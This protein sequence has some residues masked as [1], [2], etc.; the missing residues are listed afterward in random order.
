MIDHL[1]Q[2][3]D[4]LTPEQVSRCLE[5]LETAPW[6]PTTVFGMSGTEVN[7]DIRKNER[8]CVPEETELAE[9]MHSAM[10][11]ALLKYRHEVEYN[12][13]TEF[14]KYPVPGSYRTNSHRESIQVLSYT[15]DEFYNWHYDQATN[16]KDNA[17]HRTISIVLYLQNAEEGGKTI[18]PHRAYKPKAGQ[19]LIFPS[20]WCFPHRG[21]EVLK[22]RKI[23]AVTWYH[24]FYNY[25][26]N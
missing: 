22:G 10:N 8:Y 12:L 18:F 13:H 16:H 6:E 20:N 9:T 2:A 15:E 24:C 14:G 23:A 5:L 26:Q 17:Y 19:A 3:V 25:D 21:E 1:V 7:T 4:C 11:A